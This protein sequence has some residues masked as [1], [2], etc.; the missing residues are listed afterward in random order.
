M[1][2]VKFPDG[3][4]KEFN[5]G[6][7]LYEISK[8]ISNSLTKNAVA[9]RVNG[10]LKDL[11]VQIDKDC[12]VQIVTK[13]EDAGLETRP[14]GKRRAWRKFFEGER[15]KWEI[16]AASYRQDGIQRTPMQK[17][18]DSSAN[19]HGDFLNEEISLSDKL[20]KKL[21]AIY[22][23]EEET[24]N[25]T[26]SRLEFKMAT[27]LRKGQDI[28]FDVLTAVEELEGFAINREGPKDGCNVTLTWVGPTLLIHHPGNPDAKPDKL[29]FRVRTYGDDNQGN[30]EL[31]RSDNKVWLEAKIRLG[32]E[33]EDHHWGAH[34]RK[35]RV[36]VQ[37]NRLNE[38]IRLG[39][40]KCGGKQGSIAI[41]A[42]INELL[43]SAYEETENTPS[44]VLVMGRMLK[45]IYYKADWVPNFGA[46]IYVT[47]R[48]QVLY[49]PK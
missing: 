19:I 33:S 30:I 13:H 17:M 29:R 21:R 18:F 7:S 2:L 40:G 1:P 35:I 31:Q 8:S 22:R 47:R 9:A 16:I 26:A 45:T 23:T 39:T 15:E 5:D 36:L 37:L 4:E 27:R 44:E 46:A 24:S 32:E 48:A 49:L 14:P 10:S 11:S 12:S 25:L 43:S 20:A 38:L 6:V 3:S 42:S 34:N 41:S 28:E